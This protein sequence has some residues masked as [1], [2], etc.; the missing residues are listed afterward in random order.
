MLLG[1]YFTN[2]DNSKKKIFFSGI[3]F[4]TKDIKK[5]NI[6]FAI[7]GNHFDG[8]KF[9]STA[10]KK[11]SRIII[12]EK[13]VTKAQKKSKIFEKKRLLFQKLCRNSNFIY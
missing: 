3:S 2:I 13:R 7:K 11:G 12:S 9:I 10:I 5:D 4:N 6:F 8:N 1:N